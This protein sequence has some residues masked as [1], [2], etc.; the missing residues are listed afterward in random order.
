[1]INDMVHTVAIIEDDVVVS[2][3][4]AAI[5]RSDSSLQLIGTACSVA[6][7]A[8]L[9]RQR[10]DIAVLDIGLTDGSGLEL[11]RLRE[12]EDFGTCKFLILTV[13]GDET[14]VMN[15]LGAGADGYLIK[16]M[17]PDQFLQG[18][19]GVLEGGTPLSASIATYLLRNFR[20]QRT[21]EHGGTANVALNAREIE[22]LRLFATGMT[23]KEA[24]RTLGLSPYTV[25][26]YVKGIFRK[27]QVNSRA[28]AVF[29]AMSEQLFN[30]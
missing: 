26:D 10:P 19:H 22:L 12:V 11:L 30:S 3:H 7:G 21:E 5:V 14:S 29:K 24:A 16:D 17:L 15:A 4:L 28:E 13:F 8:I 9:L 18:L 6:E 20:Q 25:S 2:D 27:L 1:M 23:N